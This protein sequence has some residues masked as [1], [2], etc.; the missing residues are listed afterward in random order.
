MVAHGCVPL[1]LIPQKDH[2]LAVEKILTHYLE[3]AVVGVCRCNLIRLATTSIMDNMTQFKVQASHHNS[4]AIWRAM[5]TGYW[6][7]VLILAG[8]WCCQ[9][10]GFGIPRFKLDEAVNE[11]D[12]IVVAEVKQGRDLGLGKPVQ[13]RN[14]MLAAE[15]YSADLSVARTIK[16][17]ALREISVTYALPL[18]PVGYTGL[19]RGIRMVFLRRDKNEYHVV[20]PYYSSFPATLEPPEENTASGTPVQVVLTNMLAVLASASTS[21]SEKYEILRVDYA[22]PSNDETIAAL[23]KA[24]S[25]SADPELSEKIQGELIRFGDLGQLPAAANL[26]LRNSAP[27]NERQW[28]LDAIGNHV[29]DARAVPALARL[30]TS[31]DD[32]V[33][34]AAV[35]ALW[36]IGAPAVVPALA[37]KLQDPDEK[38]QFYAVRGLSD[39][40]NE[41][42]WGGPSEPEFHE[43]AQKYL[44]HWQEWAKNRAQ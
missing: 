41:Y 32:S 14:E 38:V 12:L 31:P 15:A 27:P 39:I 9:S 17:P 44:T 3:T 18:I 19:N 42:G 11:A 35:E 28:L 37:E 2:D 25:V 5:K 29:K 6:I 16:G 13:L 8:F 10:Q 23:Q 20:N 4:E 21:S 34:E 40:A 24:L 7:C 1:L 26:L 43:H 33:R 22:L 36:H 30:L